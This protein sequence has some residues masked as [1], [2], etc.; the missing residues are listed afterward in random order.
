MKK[1]CRQ[2]YSVYSCNFQ[3]R[4]EANSHAKKGTFRLAN[5]QLLFSD[6]G[7]FYQSQSNLPPGLILFLKILILRNFTKK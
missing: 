4:K 6:K 7:K 1:I 3:T 5:I 2:W